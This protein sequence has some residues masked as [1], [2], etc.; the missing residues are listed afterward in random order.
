[1]SLWLESRLSLLQNLPSPLVLSG[2]EEWGVPLLIEAL[3]AATPIAW[4]RLAPRDARDPAAQANALAGSLNRLTN[5]RLF[6]QGLPA[7][8]HLQVLQQSRETDPVTIV[9]SEAQ[10]GPE[11]AAQL[12]AVEAPGIRVILDYAAAPE[13]PE[14]VEQLGPLDLA[15]T[16]DESLAL[17]GDLLSP[18]SARSL[19]NRAGGRYPQ[20]VALMN[21]QLGLPVPE[22][23]GPAGSSKPV[24]AAEPVPPA[25]LIAALRRQSRLVEALEVAV[26][27]APDLV[28]ELLSQAGPEYQQR[29]LLRRLHLLLSSLDPPW[30]ESER[31]LEWRL[32][33]GSAENDLQE[34]I[35]CIDRHLE[36]HGAP[37]LRARRA[38]LL[39][40]P[41]GQAEARRAVELARTPLTVWQY[42]R[43]HKDNEAA[44]TLLQES[45]QLAEQ[46]GDPYSISRNAG[47][48]AERYLHS[49]Q[50]H[51]AVH[52]SQWALR[53]LERNEINDGFRRLRLLNNWAFCRILTGDV[54]GLRRLLLD[55]NAGL[56]DAA[57][58]LV[59]VVRTTLASL[60]LAYGEPEAA[61]DVL[62]APYAGAIRINQAR[63]A[64]R[65]VRVLLETGDLAEAEHL[66]GEA[67][68]LASSEV[69]LLRQSAHLA[70][71]MVL[72]FKGDHGG[73]PA[74]LDVMTD[75]QLPMEDRLT[76]RLYSQ[77]LDGSAPAP[78]DVSAV[79]HGLSP[80]ALQVLS[81]PEVRFRNI[82]RSV[83]GESTPLEIEV[84][85]R[86]GVRLDKEPLALTKRMWEVL[87]AL[88][89]HENG[90]TDEQLLDFLVGDS[91]AFGISAL[92]T[93]VSRVRSLIP[94]SD[95]PYQLT[96]PYTLDATLMREHLRNGRIREALTLS[97]GPFLP[98]SNSPGI[99]EVRA[100]LNEELRQAVLQSSDPEA[101]FELAEREDQDLELWEAAA[102]TLPLS[103]TRR[104]LAL[105]RIRRLQLVY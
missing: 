30:S 74:L 27:S 66:A 81:G 23:P 76:A 44:I 48:L 68:A 39:P 31:A 61:R 32:V 64:Y 29:G 9:L 57:P 67:L 36:L 85:G 78:A 4:I 6:A 89:W 87:S 24:A 1:M 51:E 80:I 53:T 98:A 7:R 33:A 62:N 95:N 11:L 45:V 13:Q 40:S 5:S 47:A 60:E 38:A 105:A 21:G 19:R 52:W 55:L 70:H 104:A 103:D 96:L 16:A 73:L 59:D 94:I 91:A 63:H 37:D 83:L 90:L 71:A 43:M 75:A 99:E 46:V 10:Y 15:L 50:F 20:F 3:G 92:R 14:G 77:L 101:L 84:L 65:R 79:L 42:G 69:P 25:L 88:A 86:P 72:A 8:Y 34:I 26:M 100:D 56:A 22:V 97:A 41:L 12:L 2:G 54:T 28:E 93:H 35:P 17:A 102:E 82:W 18:A 49:G 58:S